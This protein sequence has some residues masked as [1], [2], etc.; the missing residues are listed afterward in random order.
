MKTTTIY[1]SVKE[2]DF[3][4][5]DKI[6]KS[7]LLRLEK[8]SLKFYFPEKKEHCRWVFNNTNSI[9]KFN[10]SSLKEVVS[11]LKKKEIIYLD[12]TGQF[13][14]D[15]TFN[16]FFSS[17]YKEIIEDS[18]FINLWHDGLSYIYMNQSSFINFESEDIVRIKNFLIINNINFRDLN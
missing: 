16:Y 6:K 4:D 9:L 3:F 11:F 18:E 2:L 5:L 15:L 14:I 12:S 17:K 7:T 8:D 1:G 13:D 10:H